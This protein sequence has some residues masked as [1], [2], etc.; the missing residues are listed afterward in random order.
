VKWILLRMPPLAPV[1]EGF[2]ILRIGGHI[3]L[4][5]ALFIF[6]LGSFI[7]PDGMDGEPKGKTLQDPWE[8]VGRLHR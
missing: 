3:R 2:V 4:L 1:R 6:G 8:S 7:R 5:E